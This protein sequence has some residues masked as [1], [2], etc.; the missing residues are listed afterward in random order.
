MIAAWDLNVTPMRLA[1]YMFS[2]IRMWGR[3]HIQQPTP[4]IKEPPTRPMGPPPHTYTHP[5]SQRRPT[6]GL[7]GVPEG[8]EPVSSATNTWHHG[9]P[10]IS[11]ESRACA[12]GQKRSPG[13]SQNAAGREKAPSSGQ[14]RNRHLGGK[15]KGGR[16]HGWSQESPPACRGEQRGGKAKGVPPPPAHVTR[17]QA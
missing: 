14:W 8:E 13:R 12:A 10:R 15:P 2:I 6:H 3:R 7:P 17:T 4:P 5:P 1:F 9:V 16:N 11:A